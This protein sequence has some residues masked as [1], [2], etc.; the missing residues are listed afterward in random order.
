MESPYRRSW[1]LREGPLQPR[2]QRQALSRTLGNAW[3]ATYSLADQASTGPELALSTRL[4]R[5]GLLLEIEQAQ[6]SLSRAS[7]ETQDLA[8]QVAALNSRLSD[9]RLTPAKRTAL[10]QQRN[11][12]QQQLFRQLPQVRFR[13]SARSRP[14]QP[15]QRMGCWLSFSATDPGWVDRIPRINGALRG[16]WR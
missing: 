6:A 7:E 4:L 13:G 12:L 10:R 15:C 1:L 3:E 2:A 11:D 9:V 16:I 14:Q 8:Q 5:H